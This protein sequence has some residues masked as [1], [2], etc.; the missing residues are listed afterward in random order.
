[1][2]RECGRI[3]PF[4]GITRIRFNGSSDFSELSA[5]RA[6]SPNTVRVRDHRR[7]V[8]EREDEPR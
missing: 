1:M 7:R 4:A 3:L 8:K 2:P 5:G 6:G